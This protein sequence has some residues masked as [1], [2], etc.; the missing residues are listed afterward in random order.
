MPIVF[1][2]ELRIRGINPYLQ[3]SR[4]RARA[5]RPNWRKALPVVVRLEGKERPAWHVNLMPAGDGSFYLY[6]NSGMRKATGTSVGAR[7]RVEIRFDPAYRGGPQNPVPR[8]FQRALKADAVASINWNRLPPSRKKEVVRYL[9]RLR[10]A[11]ARER[12][13]ARALHV[14][15]GGRA[16]FLGREWKGGA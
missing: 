9:V 16:R 2:S 13:L 10:S 6:L 11:S 14:L 4:A 3:V 1:S 15:A 8:W 7:L 5:L 12:N